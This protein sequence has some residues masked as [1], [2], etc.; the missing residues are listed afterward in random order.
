LVQYLGGVSDFIYGPGY[1]RINMSLFKDFTTWREQRLEF[2]ADIFNLFNHPTWGTPSTTTDNSNGGEITGPMTSQN[3]T[4]D[5][6]FFQ[7]PL[8]Y[9]F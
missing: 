6:R 3:N 8:K 2:R 7:L 4:P 5:A 1:N 9:F